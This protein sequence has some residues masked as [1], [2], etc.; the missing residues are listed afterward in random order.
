VRRL[1]RKRFPQLLHNPRAGRMARDVEV[2]DASAVVADDEECVENAEGETK[3]MAD[4][5]VEESAQTVDFRAGQN[6]DEPQ[7]T[8]AGAVTMVYDGDSNRVSETEAFFT[9]T[10]TPSHFVLSRRI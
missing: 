10:L 8:A 3:L 9:R 4:R 1:A 5:R 7:P 6:F 2:Q